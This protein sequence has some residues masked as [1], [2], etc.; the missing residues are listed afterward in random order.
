[1]NVF[2]DRKEKDN[3]HLNQ[4]SDSLFGVDLTP[5]EYASIFKTPVSFYE[6][7]AHVSS[8][9][10]KWKEDKGYGSLLRKASEVRAR[11]KASVREKPQQELEIAGDQAL[12]N[13]PL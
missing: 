3:P 1:M 5:N 7:K 4:T 12:M 8:L 2:P 9:R 11:R 10:R 6:K 13:L